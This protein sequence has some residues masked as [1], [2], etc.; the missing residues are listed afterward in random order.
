MSF[1]SISH[2]D[3]KQLKAIQPDGWSDIATEFE[4]Y[5]NSDYCT[6]IKY[7]MDGK[8][9]GVGASIAFER[10]AWLAHIIVDSNYR[11]KGIG[12]DIVNELI[13]LLK[14]D[15][16]TET[17]LLIATELGRPLYLKF[18]FKDVSNYL[19]MKREQPWQVQPISPS[20]TDFQEEFRSS[21]YSID[22]EVTGE[23]REWLIDPHIKNSKVYIE[24]GKVT[25]YYLPG[26]REGLI[27]AQ[28]REAGL[29]LM[30]FKY[31]TAYKAVLPSE[32]KVGVEFLK[33][34]GFAEISTKGTKMLMGNDLEWN[35]SMMYSRISGNF[36]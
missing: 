31:S 35:P 11:N 24:K 34:N 14:R 10:T 6:P 8:I 16:S 22:L 5:I 30:K 1:D 17:F 25:G 13:Y 36:G 20:I 27:Y 32:N 3:L 7:E 26:L 19:F 2:R 15:F 21:I 23:R 12:F 28:T 18:G 4:F 33:A 29:E 9:V